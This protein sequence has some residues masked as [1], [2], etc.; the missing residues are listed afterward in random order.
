MAWFVGPTSRRAATAQVGALGTP[1]CSDVQ[2]HEVTTW[3][4]DA[5]AALNRRHEVFHAHQYRALVGDV[6]VPR[7][8]H[9][10][11]QAGREA[12][13]S[14]AAAVRDP[15]ERVEHAGVELW[16]RLQH[17]V[18]ACPDDLERRDRIDRIHPDPT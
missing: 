8:V 10:R 7:I 15:L 12:V 2:P 14:D 6:W 4:D 9:I 18:R 11:T 13:V 5:Q 3:F 1:E 16:M 17:E